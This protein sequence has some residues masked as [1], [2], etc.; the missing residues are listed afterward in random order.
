MNA[1]PGAVEDPSDAPA[2]LHPH[3][4]VQDSRTRIFQD[5]TKRP[6]HL[7][8]RFIL[9]V[10]LGGTLGTAA[11]YGF[12]FLL[13]PVEGIPWSIF[14]ANLAG[15]L[16]LGFLLEFLIRR[17]PEVGIYR[18]LRLFVGTGF[19][20]GFTTYSALAADTA[21]LMGDDR[22]GLGLLYATGSLLLGLVAAGIG[23]ATGSLVSRS[24][25]RR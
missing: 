8:A 24:G 19:L 3:R 11:R 22:V 23:I 21:T 7:R 6:I 15:S 14:V 13:P 25:A 10:F 5:A 9:L 16:L 18:S 17:G 1:K 12:G 20:G 2:P 4:A